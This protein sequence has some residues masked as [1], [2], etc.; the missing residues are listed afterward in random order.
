MR[1]FAISLAATFLLGI[2]GSAGAAK[3][4]PAPDFAVGPQYDTTH[5]YVA[6]EDYDR[7]MASV[8]ATF[9]GTLSKQGV[10][11]VTPTPSKT[12]SQLALTP[13]GTISAFGFKTPIPYPFGAER[14]GYLVTNFDAAVKAARADGADVIVSPFPDPIGRDAV[15]VWPGGVAMQIYWHTTP[16][17]YAPLATIPENRVYVSAS[18]ANDFI[19]AFVKFAHAKIVSDD[20]KAPGIEIGR[21]GE[22]YRRVRIESGF[23]KM[24]VLV[25]DGHLPYPYGRELTGY[26]V[27]DLDATLARATGAGATILVQPYISDR[28]RAAFVQFPGGC[29]VEIHSASLSSGSVAAAAPSIAVDLSAGPIDRT[30]LAHWEA[31]WNSHDIDTVLALFSPDVVINQPSNPKP[32]D[33]AGARGFFGMIFKAYPDFHIAVT[34]SVIE[35]SKAVSIERVTGTWSGPFTDPATGA[36]TPGNGRQF[37]HPGVMVLTYRPDHKISRLDIYWDRLV[38]DQQL[39]IKP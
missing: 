28:R 4:A 14:T 12:I 32:L 1:K 23:G 15:V 8:V 6:P 39:D 38:V 22:T 7:F 36:T 26:D 27:A 24:A 33:F 31:A 5:I 16:P 35:G 18:R 3:V 34:D 9:G 29:V 2:P 20:A 25:T 21:P 19:H 11:Q 13:A 17:S 37:D 10:F 30:D